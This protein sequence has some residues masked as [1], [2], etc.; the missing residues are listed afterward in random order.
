ME[1]RRTVRVTLE[2]DGRD[3]PGLQDIVE[4]LRLCAQDGVGHTLQGEAVSID[5]DQ[6]HEEPY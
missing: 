5:T 1:M 2:V 6:L 4:A 3:A